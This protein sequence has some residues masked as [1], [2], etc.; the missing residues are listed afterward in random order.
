MN[1]VFV[2]WCGCAFKSPFVPSSN[3]EMGE[4][5]DGGCGS[6]FN[7]HLCYGVAT[8]NVELFLAIVD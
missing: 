8:S 1:G 2:L 3:I 7:Y 4:E 5:F 6:V